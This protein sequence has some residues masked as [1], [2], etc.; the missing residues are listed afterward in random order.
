MDFA[1][2]FN[3]LA[4]MPLR[5]RFLVAGAA[6][7]IATNSGPLLEIFRRALASLD[8]GALPE[9][10]ISFYVDPAGESN[11]GLSMPCL[12][13]LGHLVFAGFDSENALLVDLRARQVVGRFSRRAA[14][15]REYW[16]RMVFPLVLG[17]AGGSVGV[18]ALHCGCVARDGDGLILAGDSGAG[19]STL[20]LALAQRGFAFLSDEWTY[21]SRRN[22]QSQAWGLP[23]PLKLLPDAAAFFPE[24]GAL[25]PAPAMNG[26]LAFEV[27]PA[28]VF[29]VRRACSCQPRWLIWLER[30]GGQGFKLAE[31]APAETAPRFE[32]GLLAEEPTVMNA[33]RETIRSLLGLPG[34]LLR[35]GG[36]PQAIALALEHFCETG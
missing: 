12:R 19:K 31:I 23:N 24:L 29:G 5:E 1:G 33:Q 11:P 22:G 35:Y 4:Q 26:E 15:D 36:N 3:S 2:T 14:A 30:E 21:F 13:G 34:A 8:D 18:T 17:V 9:L 7:E 32:D 25:E 27:D 10:R 28:G 20:S 6:C 16:M